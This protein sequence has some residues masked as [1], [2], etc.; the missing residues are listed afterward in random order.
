[1]FAPAIFVQAQGSNHWQLIHFSSLVL[2]Y[3]YDIN[4]S[5]VG[6]ISLAY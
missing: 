2:E 5:T 4:L 6:N 1:M 3:I